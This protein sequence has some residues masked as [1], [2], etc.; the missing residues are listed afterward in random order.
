MN[1]FREINSKP[2]RWTDKSGVTHAC[3]GAEVHRGMAPLLW[4]LCQRDVPA[5]KAWHPKQ[6][7]H[8]EMCMACTA[9]LASDEPT[10]ETNGQDVSHHIMPTHKLTET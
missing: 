9:A 2:I 5:N 6:G 7:D 8:Y 4:T 1:T 10:A 3:E